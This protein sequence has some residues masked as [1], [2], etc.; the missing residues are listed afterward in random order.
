MPPELEPV[1]ELGLMLVADG[2]EKKSYNWKLIP[3]NSNPSLL[4]K[5]EFSDNFDATMMYVVIP[6]LDVMRFKKK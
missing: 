2:Q 1:A 3:L 4:S 6:V 5:S